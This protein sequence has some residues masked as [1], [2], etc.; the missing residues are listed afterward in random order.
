MGDDEPMAI[1]HCQLQVLYLGLLE[2]DDRTTHG[3]NQ[4]VVMIGSDGKFIACEPVVEV[5][6]MRDTAFSQHLQRPVHGGVTDASVLLSH[7]GQQFIDTYM[8][9][10][11]HERVDDEASLLRRSHA[12]LHHV[13]VQHVPQMLCFRALG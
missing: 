8:G 2:F 1:G 12:M 7:L 13:G 4:V 10:R 3:T 11:R 9:L 6:L 5:A